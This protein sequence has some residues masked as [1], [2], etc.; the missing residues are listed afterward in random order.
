M[1]VYLH[2]CPPLRAAVRPWP[3]GG[4]LH[5]AAVGQPT[6]HAVSAGGVPPALK[7]MLRVGAPSGSPRVVAAVA[8]SGGGARAAAFGLGVLEELKATRLQLD[9]TRP[10][11]STRWG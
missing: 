6:S 10:R 11:C 5:H 4:L 3:A 9:A 7:P 2:A 1:D 8:L